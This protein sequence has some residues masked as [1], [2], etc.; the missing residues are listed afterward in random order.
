MG[1]EN[2]EPTAS[3]RATNNFHFQHSL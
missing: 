3:Q 2:Y 1:H